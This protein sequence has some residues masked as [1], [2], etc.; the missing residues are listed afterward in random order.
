MG[1]WGFGIFEDD[2]TA[3]I[4]GDFMDALDGGASVAEA[5]RRVL[6]EHAFSA[7]DSD[8]GPNVWLAL[9]ALQL[10]HGQLEPWI[11]ALALEVTNHGFGLGRW[12]DAGSDELAKRKLVLD[13]LKDKLLAS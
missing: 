3:D 4:R 11:K 7:L 6:E 5:T 9:A 1:A 10:E 8:D 13:E 12:E 2:E